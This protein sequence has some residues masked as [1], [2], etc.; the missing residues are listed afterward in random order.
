MS[1]N[2]NSNWYV[3]EKP[4]TKIVRVKKTYVYIH[5][6]QEQAKVTLG[7][8]GGITVTSETGY[9]LWKSMK[10]VEVL[11]LNPKIYKPLLICKRN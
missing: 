10:S 8:E 7:I 9:W 11:Y 3:N 5:E 1:H 4:L 2:Y 6:A